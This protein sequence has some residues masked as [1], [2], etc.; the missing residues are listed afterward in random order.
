VLQPGVYRGPLVLDHEQTLIGVPGAIVKGGIVVKADNVTI[1]H[2][3]VV[4]GENGIDVEWAEHV[5]LDDV[6][7]VGAKLDGIHARRSSVSISDCR[8]DSPPGYT[9]G[10]DISFAI[11]LDMSMVEGCTV[12]GGQE[13][14]VT[15]SVMAAIRD[16]HVTGT[17]LRGITMTEMS[18]GEVEENTISDVLGVGIY[19][20]DRS[21]CEIADNTILDVRADPNGDPS[22]A[23]IGVVSFFGAHAELEGN[24]IVGARESATFASATITKA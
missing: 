7:V 15:N 8:I 5:H 2:V 17:S 11:D 18:M 4:G 22:R 21:E 24:E 20:G 12:T 14:I 16:N 10:I 1:R 13:G 6:T 9:Q 19:C 3:T 23:G